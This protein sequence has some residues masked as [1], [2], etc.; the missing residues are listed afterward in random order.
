MAIFI[1][2]MVAAVVV[3]Q[4]INH[5]IPQVPVPLLEIG[6]GVILALLPTAAKF[7]FNPEI[8]LMGIIAPLMFNDGQ[9]TNRRALGHNLMSILMLSVVLV[10]ATAILVAFGV[11][12]WRPIYGFW[13]VFVLVA[14]MSPTDATAVSGLTEK[15]K[16][17]SGLMHMLEGESLFND[18]TGIVLFNFGIASLTFGK[19]PISQGVGEFLLE[20][21]GG[22]LL[23]VGL[24]YLF[25]VA[26]ISLQRVGMDQSSI[27]VPI[28]LATPFV[29]YL[30]GEA[31]GVSG[32]LAVVAAG[33]IHG[34]EKDRLRLTSSRLQ[35]VT[36]TVWRV[37][38]DL[39]NGEVFVMLGLVLPG[40][41]RDTDNLGPYLFGA[42]VLYLAMTGV[43]WLFIRFLVDLP[44]HL[45]RSREATLMT[46]FGSHGAVTLALALAL[47]ITFPRR[48]TVIE[49][50]ALVILMSLIVPTVLGPF[51][52]PPEPEPQG[53]DFQKAR[54][55]MLQ[56][57]IANFERQVPNSP[58][59]LKVL[60]D[61]RNQ[62]VTR[63]SFDMVKYKAIQAGAEA[64]EQEAITQAG[65]SGE[66][67]PL[68]ATRYLN[69]IQRRQANEHRNIFKAIYLKIVIS[70]IGRRKRRQAQQLM[71]ANRI[72]QQK[73]EDG[74][75]ALQKAEEIVHKA[76][77]AWLAQ[78]APSTEV[79]QVQLRYQQRYDRLNRNE[80]SEDA[81]QDLYITVFQLEYQYVKSEVEA[82]K[83][84]SAVAQ[85]L[86][87]QI[88]YDEMVYVQGQ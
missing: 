64:Q 51:I 23:G 68:M 58:E 55:Q 46:V 65:Q 1:L 31:L 25:V 83:M 18:A 70:I 75:L 33:M 69:F 63:D 71:A 60:N 7:E 53:P 81:L 85:Q 86:R 74:R 87:E 88:S 30:A 29:V 66:L 21:F 79:T 37:V 35:V 14:L 8:F 44:L 4:V 28:Q 61:L 77:M 12:W 36:S 52:L 45:P 22:I 39:L 80:T 20:F 41:V 67:S 5:F 9:N 16:I 34:L 73:F 48:A 17:P 84:S 26:R 50:A 6:L 19:L 38:A 27:M 56:E 3:A 82:K 40:V 47:P 59:K 2:A 72:D 10:T 11:N 42:V 78:Q 57:V 54:S 32:I 62:H 76:V 13:P 43:R 49:L 15:M 24:G